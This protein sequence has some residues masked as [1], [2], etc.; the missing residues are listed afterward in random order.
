MRNIDNWLLALV[1]GAML[2]TAGC[3]HDNKAVYEE[4]EPIEVLEQVTLKCGE[5]FI[6]TASS[7]YDANVTVEYFGTEEEHYG[8]WGLDVQYTVVSDCNDCNNTDVNTT[9]APVDGKC[10]CGL[11]LNACGTD[12]VAPEKTCDEG[13][14][15]REEICFP[16]IYT[17]FVDD[18]GHYKSCI[19]GYDWNATEE[20]CEVTI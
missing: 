13:F 16:D 1:F 9:S 5:P 18:D 3:K 19:D 10:G 8:E 4:G 17:P 12:C 2:F 7:P 14:H 15:L 20:V 11:E 6:F